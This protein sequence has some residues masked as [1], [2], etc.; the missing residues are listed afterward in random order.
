MD[1]PRKPWIEGWALPAWVGLALALLSVAVPGGGLTS[2]GARL[3]IRIT[4][5]S[6]FLLFAAAFLAGPL[7]QR[8]PCGATAWLRRNRRY[9]GLSFAL[10]HA[11]HGAW[12]LVYARLDPQLFHAMVKSA[13]Y[14]LGGIGYGF[15]VSLAATSF[16]RTAA[17]L[18]QRNWQRLHWLGT[19]YLW[20]QFVVSFARR[21]P[22]DPFYCPLAA[23]A[24]ALVVVRLYCRWAAAPSPTRLAIELPRE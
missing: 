20:L 4:A 23:C 18:G 9:L 15:I 10:S 24:L 7:Y 21:A 22:A 6:S 2:D 11:V 3:M 12:V 19:H 16:E 14:V 17:L 5:R 8:W 13:N 1:T